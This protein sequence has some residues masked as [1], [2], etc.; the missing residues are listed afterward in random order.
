MK[1]GAKRCLNSIQPRTILWMQGDKRTICRD[2]RAMLK[3]LL[4]HLRATIRG[5]P[6]A[7]ADQLTDLQTTAGELLREGTEV[8]HTM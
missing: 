3:M 2:K 7:Q 4:S 1:G 5:Q 6:N 8:R